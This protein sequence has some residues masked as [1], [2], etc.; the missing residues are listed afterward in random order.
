MEM[1]VEENGDT[2]ITIGWLCFLSSA[3]SINQILENKKKRRYTQISEV[4]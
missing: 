1:V 3:M 4:R 2:T